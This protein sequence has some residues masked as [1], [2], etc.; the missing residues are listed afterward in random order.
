MF[1]DIWMDGEED[2][3]NILLSFLGFFPFANEIKIASINNN[4]GAFFCVTD[5]DFVAFLSFPMLQ[6]IRCLY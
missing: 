4:R 1:E 5:D 6:L 2:V 3:L